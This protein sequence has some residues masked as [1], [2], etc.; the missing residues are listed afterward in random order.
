MQLVTSLTVEPNLLRRLLRLWDEGGDPRNPFAT[1][2]V[3][4][5]FA[6]NNTLNIIREELKE[7][8]GATVYFDSGGYY[9]Q[10][11]KIGFDELY[12]AL[13]DYYA[14]PEN[15]WGDWYVLPDHV[16]TSKDTPQVIQDKIYDT[17][18][19]SKSLF[20]QLPPSLRDRAIP[21]IQGHTD[22]QLRFCIENYLS[23]GARYMGFGSFDTCGPNESI[24]RITLGTIDLLKTV[25]EL[26]RHYDFKLHLFG[27]GSP[28]AHYL[29][30]QMQVRSFDSLTWLKAAGYGHIFLPFV[31]GY[32]ITHR[33]TE[34]VYWAEDDFLLWKGLTEH[35][36][37][38]CESYAQ[39]ADNRLF[40]I[41][42]NICV[43]METAEHL[44]T[45]SA[46]RIRTI[47]E[48]TSPTYLSFLARM[49]DGS[50]ISRF[51]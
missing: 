29:F 3:T 4:P 5:L 26:A 6:P 39:L 48:S 44:R 24:N 51:A 34:R 9:A 21:V 22:A 17:V 40:R 37:P 30:S 20:Y 7:K 23:F 13:R 31:R 12:H 2:L 32:R 25:N 27:I 11:G 18:T 15:Q 46:E 42:H 49:N 38:F 36:C 33:T 8:R 16:P 19:A 28:P 41:L 47:I 14:D 45:W 1:V 10:Q 50:R 43:F 35:I